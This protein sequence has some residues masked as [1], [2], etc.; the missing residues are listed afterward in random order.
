MGLCPREPHS[1][2]RIVDLTP[3]ELAAWEATGELPAS[4]EARFAG[5]T[6]AEAKRLIDEARGAGTLYCAS[7][8]DLMAPYKERERHKHEK[9]CM[10]L[11][12]KCGISLSIEDFVIKENSEGEETCSI[13]P[14]AFAEIDGSHCL[15]VVNCHYVMVNER[16][17]G[18]LRFDISPESLKFHLF[19]AIGA[20]LS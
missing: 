7:H 4:V 19:E 6:P 13:R 8:D 15:L 9:L 17:A 16:E 1:S 12:A 11:G 2:G 18:G 20:G 5:V 14:L 10:A 3:E